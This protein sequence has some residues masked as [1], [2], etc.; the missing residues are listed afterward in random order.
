MT[1]LPPEEQTQARRR[2]RIALREILETLILALLIFLAVRSVVQ[3]FRVEGVSMDPSLENGQYII[4]NKLA[5]ARIDLKIFNF[6]PFFDAGSNSVK[7]IF[8][9]PG[10]GD[11]V[12]FRSPQDRSTDFIKRI[13][14]QPGDTVEI[15]DG[16]VFINGALLEEPY[17]SGR[18][19]CHGGRQ[20]CGPLTLG[21]GR[22]YVLGDNRTSSSD[23]RLWGPVPEGDIIGKAWFSYWPLSQLGLAPN[24]SVGFATP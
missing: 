10:R 16:T 21:E 12:V 1:E 3:N 18:T 17:A 2:W 22:Y 24:H 4:V 15:R 23:S 9:G 8:G 5:Y 13:I 11:V 7:H 19:N 6:L 20:R 14:G